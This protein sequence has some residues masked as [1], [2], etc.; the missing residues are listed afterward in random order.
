[1]CINQQAGR[2]PLSKW[3]QFC[4]N[5]YQGECDFP[6]SDYKNKN[7]K[8]GRNYAEAYKREKINTTPMS[9]MLY[10]FRLLKIFFHRRWVHSDSGKEGSVKT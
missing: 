7:G 8:E 1:M 4:A 6:S 2:L 10:F 9:L 5:I 3:E